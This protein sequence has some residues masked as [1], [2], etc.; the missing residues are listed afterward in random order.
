MAIIE[1]KNLSQSVQSFVL[2]SPSLS[3][4]HHCL[5]LRIVSDKV[6]EVCQIMM[7]TVNSNNKNNGIDFSAQISSIEPVTSALYAS[8]LNHALY[9]NPYLTTKTPVGTH[10]VTTIIKPIEFIINVNRMS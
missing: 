10:A 3:C 6:T 2:P 7:E 9:T 1:L 5:L 4:I 8:E